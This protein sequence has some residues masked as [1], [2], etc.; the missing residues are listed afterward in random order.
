[1]VL[2]TELSEKHVTSQGGQVDD[3]EHQARERR[4]SF[5]SAKTSQSAANKKTY[6]ATAGMDSRGFVLGPHKFV[7]HPN[8]PYYE[9]RKTSHMIIPLTY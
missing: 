1:M 7:I 6:K 8:S 2:E 4:E 3:R 9:V 5:S